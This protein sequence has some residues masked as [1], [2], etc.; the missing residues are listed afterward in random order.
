MCNYLEVV[1][2]PGGG[3]T[4]ENG[5]VYSGDVGGV[6]ILCKTLFLSLLPGVETSR[7]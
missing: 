6:T 4:R 2:L 3:G 5:W 1:A 7:D